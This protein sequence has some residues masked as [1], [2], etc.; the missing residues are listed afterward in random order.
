MLIF[1]YLSFNIFRRNLLIIDVLFFILIF[2]TYLTL[3][4]IYRL[5]PNSNIKLIYKDYVILILRVRPYSK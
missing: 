2:R 1:F 5:S 3:S 4:L